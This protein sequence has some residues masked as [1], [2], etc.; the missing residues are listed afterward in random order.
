M[1]T[2]LYQAR[3]QHRNQVSGDLE[4][5]AVGEVAD[6]LLDRGLTPIKIEERRTPIK[7]WGSLQQLMAGRPQAVDL[8]FFCRQMYSITKAGVPIHRGVR[9]LTES[10]RHPLLRAA[11]VDIRRKLEEGRAL[12]DAMTGHK[13]IFPSLMV[14]VIRVGEHTGRLDQA[15]SELQRNLELEQ[16][17]RRQ[18][19]TAF[20]YPIMVLAAI[21]VAVGVVNLLVVP[22]FAR[23][24]AS[25]EVD[26]PIFTRILIASSEWTVNWWPYC[27]AG[28][29]AIWLGVRN[30]LKQPKGAELWGR[31]SLRVPL[32]GPIVMRATLARFARTLAMCLRAGVAMDQAIRVVAAAS[33]N[34]HIALR[35]GEMRDRIAKGESLSAASRRADIFTPLVLQMIMTGEETG[36]IDEML[37]EAADFYEREVSYDVKMLG[38]YIEPV[39][40]AFVSGLVLCLALGIFL[41]MWDLAGAV[42][43]R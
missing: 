29:I 37:D 14:N 33:S 5:R 24:F 10:M 25:L 42:L 21:I 31:W 36:R 38:D 8:I 6:M 35:L 20:R 23:V 1:P 18:M 30:Y 7:A 13:G 12:S 9:T 32:L 22:T 16:A 34:R 15:F 19:K 43:R 40:I 17:T 3:D 11:L 28:G 2:F 26:L 4:A 27:V 39:L 41:P